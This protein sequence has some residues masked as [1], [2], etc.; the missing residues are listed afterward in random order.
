MFEESPRTES[1]PTPEP[2]PTGD[3]APPV[4]PRPP[5]VI[6]AYPALF[7][8][9]GV[10]LAQG[11]GARGAGLLAGVFLILLVHAAWMHRTHPV[12]ELCT[13]LAVLPLV[14]LVPVLLGPWIAA[15][16]PWHL[17]LASALLALAALTAAR[18]LGYTPRDLGLALGPWRQ[19]GRNGAASVFSAAVALPL[20]N[21]AAHTF[22]QAGIA[23]SGVGIGTLMLALFPTPGLVL[24]SP[25]SPLPAMAAL[26]LAG[27]TEELVY[28]GVLQH[29]AVRALGGTQGVVYTAVTFGA[30]Y[31][32]FYPLEYALAMGILGLGFGFLALRTG[33]ILGIGTAHA[34]ANLVVL[35][36][37]PPA[38]LG[39]R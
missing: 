17:G 37:L 25:A 21:M 30:M 11:E 23:V 18:V 13:A 4:P 7:A 16:S 26:G 1:P 5:R 9:A 14:H 19:R 32:G 6:W 22:V 36:Y 29:A 3:N 20:V 12:S 27:L 8:L 34:L 15:G 28:R 38:F 10:W 31:I 2:P 35:G 39:V 33:S 24:P